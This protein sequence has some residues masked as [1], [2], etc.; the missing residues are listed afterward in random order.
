MATAN[1]SQSQS[2]TNSRI[3]RRSHS[4]LTWTLLA[5]APV[6]AALWTGHVLG[7]TD[8]WVGLGV[9]NNWKDPANWSGDVVP[10]ANDLLT[11][12]GANRFQPNNNF[13]SGTMFG[14][15]VFNPT[16]AGPFD[17][18]GNAVQL[19][20]NITDNTQSFTHTINLPLTL[21]LTPTISITQNGS[22]LLSG[23]ISGGFGLNETG[24]G[25]LTL[26]GTNA[27]TGPVTVGNGATLNITTDSNLGQAPASATA[28]DVILD[29]GSL[30]NIG[31]TFTLTAN[32]GIT[33]VN[34]G[35]ATPQSASISIAT[36]TGVTYDGIISDGGTV[37]GLT[38]M[39][40]GTMTL[41]GS[42]SYT[43]PTTIGNGYLITD[44]TQTGAPTTNIINSNSALTLGG[45]TAGLGDT[46]YAELFV[47]GA[48]SAVNSQ[49]F[50]G[51]T[52]AIGPAIVT[53][54]SGTGG[55]ANINLGSLTDTTGGVAVFSA[56]ASGNITTTSGN[57][58][59]ILG[60]WAVFTTSTTASNVTRNGVIQG[61]NFATVNGS[62]DI[63]AYTGYT[64]YGTAVTGDTGGLIAAG[65]PLQGNVTASTNLRINANGSAVNTVVN[66]DGA[67][68]TTDLNTISLINSTASGVTV[69]IGTGN[70]L[71]FGTYGGFFRQDIGSNAT[72]YIGGTAAGGNQSG[73]GSNGAQ[74]IGTITAGGPVSGTPGQIVFTVDANSETS[75]SVVVEPA[76]V[77]NGGGG[78]VTIVKTGAGSM[79]LDGH[80]TFSGGLDILQGRLQ[81]AGSEIGTPNPDGGGTG[82]IRVFP[83]GQWFPSGAGSA[84]S[85][86]TITNPIFLAGIGQNGDDTGAI[87]ATQGLT[88]GGTI[89]LFGNARIGGGAP[90]G[91]TG[92]YINPVTGANNPG[93]LISGQITGNFSMDFGASGNAGGNGTGIWISNP[94]NNWTGNT[95]IL[96]RTTSV[97]NSTLHL[98]APNVIPNGVGFGNVVMGIST[99]TT[100]GEVLTL[101]LDGN[102]QTINGLSSGST[103]PT[104]YVEN[105]L[106]YYPV[107][108]DGNT[109]P[110]PTGVATAPDQATLTLGNNNQTATFNGIIRDST[111]SPA[112]L[113]GTVAAVTYNYIQTGNTV[114]VTKIGTGIETFSGNSSYSG[115]TNINGGAISVTG[116]LLS[117]GTVQVNT[118]ANSAGSLFGT[119]SVGNVILAAATGSNKA[120]INPG[121]TGL[122]SVG[123]LTLSSL[124]VN[125]GD[126]LQFDTV[127]PGASDSLSI[128]GAL[129]FNGSSTISPSGGGSTGS[130][131][132]ITAGSITGT[133]PTLNSPTNTRSVFS[134]DPSSWNPTTNPTANSII[135]DVVAHAANL[136]WTGAGDGS[137]WD[138]DITKN[139]FNTGT[140]AADFFFQGDNVTFD[141]TAAPNYNVNL[142]GDTVAPNSITFN[143]TS[144]NYSLTGSGSIAGAAGIV[145]NG[146]GTLTI[147]TANSYTGANS[148]NAGR[149]V[150]TNFSAL[151]T[152]TSSGT[153]IAAGAALDL[154]G[155]TNLNDV[156][157]STMPFTIAGTGTDGNGAIVNNG[158]AQQNAFTTLSLSG[159]A[160]IGGSARFDIRSSSSGALN[161]N[162]FTLTKVGTGQFSL[163][164]VNVGSGNIVVT[165]G[166]LSVESATQIGNDGN[167]ITLDTGTTLQIFELTNAGLNRNIDVNG[168][169]VTIG[170][171]NANVVTGGIETAGSN[172]FLSDPVTIGTL[173]GTGTLQLNG[174]I[175]ETSPSQSITKSGA[176]FVYFTGNNTYS[177]GT[178]V[179]GGGIELGNNTASG[180]TITSG[181][182]GLGSLT[183]GNGTTLEDDGNQRT[184][185][186]NVSIGGSVTFD[187][188]A[189]GG[190]IT[191]DGTTLATP[192]TVTLTASPV[193]TVNANITIND[194][195]AGGINSVTI[196]TAATGTPGTLTLGSASNAWSGATAVRSGTLQLRA[197][198]ALPSGTSLTLGN[199]ATSGTLD[200]GGANATVG[201]LTTAGTGTAN[202]IGNSS[203]T[204][205]STLTFAG[206]TSTFS[207][208]ILNTL[209]GGNMNTALTVAS[210]SL[211]LTGANTYA[212]GTSIGGGATLNLGST[213]A[214]PSS[215]TVTNNGALAVNFNTTAGN[216]SG[217]GTTTV[218]T[219]VSFTA[220]NFTQG[221]L[222]NNGSTQ[223]NGNG[224]VGGVTGTGTLTI[225]TGSSANTL[226]LAT[227]SG[228]STQ[229]GLV[230]NTGSTLDITNNHLFVVYGSNADPLA[231]IAALIVSGYNNGS[232][233]GTG[234]T[235]SAAAT[236]NANSANL[237]YGLG[238]ADSADAGNPAS[239]PSGTIEIKYTLLGDAN[240]SGTVDGVDF[241]I[242]A[243]NF[244]K[245]VTGWDQGDFNYDN[246]VDGTDFGDLAAN[247]NKGA[248]GADL[249]EPA[250]DDPAIVAFAEAN[251]LMSE[252]Q[253]SVPEPASIGVIALGAC[254]LMARRRRKTAATV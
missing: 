25:Q 182:V 74:D 18:V 207:G 91:G 26:G 1:H 114:A 121:A 174:T 7:A 244:N 14:G 54:T 118:S 53:A 134:Y 43:G 141:D 49:T 95:T 147:A 210:G 75:G 146:T 153:S 85:P 111:S 245:G 103:A 250:I 138:V 98:A 143:N 202:Q 15:F 40:F 238:Y 171:N 242:L 92:D 239:L 136:V 166:E 131:T 60:G 135:I 78:T 254:G 161:L 183:L 129:A 144:G 57:T 34:A 77:D 233:T 231:S 123:H 46:S 102:N 217:T 19:N 186:N 190:G 12:D 167:A 66:T 173:G 152:N 51:T 22:L 13:A 223:V 198:G 37:G 61:T 86:Q 90:T 222:V 107:G 226:Q 185:A 191:L 219:G 225:G 203:T 212:G 208:S 125:T 151:G 73:N 27:F 246:V 8:T 213:G 120:V 99:D 72:I 124:T 89:T 63:V 237:Q 247:F 142:P 79:K 59:G 164:N 101:D 116:S 100:S 68:T 64:D 115:I 3:S 197:T 117:T 48:A 140:S 204:S 10:N 155:D 11:F 93:F 35:G 215:S 87:R 157:F 56:P 189:G 133:E 44:F 200:L 251:G 221:A 170:S 196:A 168:T 29:G 160:T 179:T 205:N 199:A 180:T 224:T 47:K 195:I 32:R 172:I 31:A 24:L 218:N 122:G 6:A 84:A 126:D 28:G 106:F 38:K 241:G 88:L 50:N 42:N 148:I 41:G 240:L 130:Y 128:N 105:D 176:N 83:G 229:S 94:A 163:V 236:N 159:N 253:A 156:G 4:K 248:S 82:P 17:L 220:S 145:K 112:T 187:P 55:T 132:L 209:S 249:G 16:A 177:G 192:A 235:S 113:T 252:L 227:N 232:W 2:R 184:L 169:G 5:T 97:G 71:R 108:Q 214:L 36:G 30:L 110:A 149:V 127:A 39:S 21:D 178:N 20:G 193:L 80:N 216:V 154:S 194:A 67:N 243:A 76:I 70:T 162:N 175:S 211:M 158:V 58:N 81:F 23:V 9:D 52:I 139:W 188:A 65:T 33:I 150:V 104:L 119:G 201:S 109:A 206:G 96:G 165:G 62:G 234:I 230:I 137:T 45:S 69:N 228:A 181:P